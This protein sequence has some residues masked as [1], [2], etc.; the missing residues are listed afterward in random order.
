MHE[1]TD[2]L[3]RFME[4]LRHHLSGW[5]QKVREDFSH[6]NYHD[7]IEALASDPVYAKFHLATPEYVFIR[8]M[9]RM[10]VS[11]GRRLGEIYDKIPRF[12]AQ[13]RYNLP[14]EEVI[15]KFE[16]LELDV[17]LR[18]DKLNAEDRKHLSAVVKKH[19]G[20]DINRFTG[21][22]IEIRYNFNPNDSSRLRKDKSLAELLKG[23]QY[24]PLYLVFAENSPRLADAVASLTR[25]GWK[26]IIG[27]SALDFMAE[28]VGFDMSKILDLELVSAEVKSEVDKLMSEIWDSYACKQLAISKT[29][30]A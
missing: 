30:S 5:R 3:K 20:V 25:G 29:P 26:F 18:P 19:I 10:S 9:G 22:A 7:E 13:A 12:V 11:I 2:A 16:G 14:R 28:L 23:E 24:F 27:T 1:N 6:K 21:L 8:L 15:A 17:R 4:E